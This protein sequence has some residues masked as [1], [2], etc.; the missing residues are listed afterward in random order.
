MKKVLILII[1]L[2]T[3]TAQAQKKKLWAKSFLHKDAPELVVEEWISEEPEIQ[4]KFVLIDF[5]ATWCGPCKKA[6]PDMNEFQE[7]FE[8]D[9]V[10][11]G[12]SDESKE[13][14]LK[15]RNPKIKYYSAIDTQKTMKKA[16]QVRGIPHCILINPDGVVVWEGY[17]L[18]K[19]N[20]LTTT[21]IKK[22]IE[23]YKKKS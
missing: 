16:L 8:E 21:V 23:L 15:Q 22:Q 13:K 12:I 18:L 4:G 3:L 6:I 2:L 20:E 10:V 11:I 7:V 14:V 17:P 19:G 5:W 9:L 1:T